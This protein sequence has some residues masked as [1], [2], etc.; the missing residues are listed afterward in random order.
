MRIKVSVS[1][2]ANPLAVWSMLTGA[3]FLF[4]LPAE[5]EF[6]HKHKQFTAAMK[7]YVRPDGVR[8][9]SWKADRKKFDEY[10]QTLESLTAEEYDLFSA[11]EKKVLWLNAYNALA[12]RLVLNNYPIQGS[13]RDYPTNSMRQIP[14]CWRAGKLKIAGRDVDLFTIKHQI[15]RSE[16]QDIRTHFSVVPASKG[17]PV[18]SPRAFTPID[19]D[20]RLTANM[21]VYLKDEAHLKF[22]PEQNTIKVSRIFRWFTLDFVGKDASGKPVFPPPPDA[23]IVQEFVLRF[24]PKEVQEAFADKRA[25]VEFLIYDWSLNESAAP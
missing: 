12:L 7:K 5:A 8:Y 24:A 15:L 18:L 11:I 22:E 1:A 6:D 23:E 25:K 14:D 21:N 9:K 10:I 17:G 19:V 13:N 2:R 3:A 16:I 4:P 20:A